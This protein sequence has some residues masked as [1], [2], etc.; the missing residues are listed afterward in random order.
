MRTMYQKYHFKALKVAQ[1]SFQ[2][3]DFDQKT[4]YP[5]VTQQVTIATV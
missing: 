5:L 4:A 1:N 2:H 3:L